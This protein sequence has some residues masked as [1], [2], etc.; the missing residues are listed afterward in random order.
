MK[1]K[2]RALPAAVAT[3]LSVEMTPHCQGDHACHVV[4][5]VNMSDSAVIAFATHGRPLKIAV[6]KLSAPPT[7]DR[8]WSRWAWS[9][10]AG[11][12][13]W[14]CRVWCI[15]GRYFLQVNKVDLREATLDYDM[16]AIRRSSGL[17]WYDYGLKKLGQL[18]DMWVPPGQFALSRWH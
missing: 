7:Q 4:P 14:E 9:L 15:S 10:L 12:W 6:S 2:T 18:T 16:H 3:Y 1:D 5:W 8:Y 11:Q 13:A 17:K